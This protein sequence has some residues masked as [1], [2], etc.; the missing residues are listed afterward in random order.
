MAI[1]DSNYLFSIWFWYDSP[2]GWASTWHLRPE[3]VLL[4]C[5]SYELCTLNYWFLVIFDS[6]LHAA[7]PG[8]TSKFQAKDVTSVTA[9]VSWTP[10]VVENQDL[11]TYQVKYCKIDGNGTVIGGCHVRN[12]KKDTSVELDS[13]ERGTKYKVTVI[14]VN[15][16]IKGKAA[17][18]EFITKGMSNLCSHI[19]Y[20]RTKTLF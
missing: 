14:A 9:T 2:P 3:L 12:E 20:T 8:P 13:L 18:F 19:L 4:Y 16:A 10:P 7:R 15:Q 17:S 5:L 11:L 6:F 1:N